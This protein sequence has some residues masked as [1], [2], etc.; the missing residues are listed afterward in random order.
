MEGTQTQTAIREDLA[1][2]IDALGEKVELAARLIAEL[3]RER[4]EL[5][6]Q[7]ESLRREHRRVLDAAQAEDTA[8]LLRAL[9]RFRELEQENQNLLLERTEVARRLGKLGEM[10]DSLDRDS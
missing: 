6:A 10:V 3:R 4:A 8:G 1:R 5:G 9:D 2:E 7:Y